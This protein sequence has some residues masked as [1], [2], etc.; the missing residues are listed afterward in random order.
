[1][2]NKIFDSISYL[3]DIIANLDKMDYR[4][5]VIAALA[6]ITVFL[7]A[8]VIIWISKQPKRDKIQINPVKDGTSSFGGVNQ[9]R[10]F[11]FSEN[12]AAAYQVPTSK[13]ELDFIVAS[14][15]VPENLN[16][17]SNKKQTFNNINQQLTQYIKEARNF[18][19]DD[20]VIAQE[21]KKVGWDEGS[22]KDALKL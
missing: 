10:R 7:L 13:E 9:G 2:E 6:I 22:I 15:S 21:L 19:M 20:K 18:G 11:K 16:L 14:N 1:M 12:V 8:L 5:W 4:I 17:Y 3:T